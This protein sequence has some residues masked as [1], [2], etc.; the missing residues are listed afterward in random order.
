MNR[1]LRTVLGIGLPMLTILA[2][3]VLLTF[4]LLRLSAIE[5]SMRLEAPHNMLWVISQA[6]VA[7]LRLSKTAAE[8][9]LDLDNAEELQRRHNVFLSRLHLLEQG[10]QWREMAALGLADELD[11]LRQQ[12]PALQAAIAA[13]QPHD[14]QR[15]AAIDTLLDPFNRLL[16]RAANKAMVAE[17]EYVGGRM[18]EARG[19]LWQIIISLVGILLAGVA[20]STHFLLAKRN[21]HQRARLLQQEKAFSEL[22]I[23]SSNDSIVAVDRHG[24]CTVWNRAAEHLFQ[25]PAA[26]VIGRRLDHVSGFFDVRAIQQ[27]IR[28]ALQGNTAILLEQPFFPAAD[29]APHYLGMRYFPLRNDGRIIGAILLI[30]DVTE[31]RAAQQEIAMHRDHLQELVQAR[32]QELD[33]ALER[34][35]AAA[36]LY[37]NFG[38]MISHQFRTPLAI[39]DSALQRL[40]RRSEKMSAAEI[41]A[42]SAK[43]RDAIKRLTLLIESTL[44]AARLDAGQIK[45]RSQ[46]CDLGQLAASVCGQQRRAA[47]GATINLALPA[48]EAPS[49]YCDPAHAEHI[50][51]NLVSNAVKY[52]SADAPI[53]VS[54]RCDDDHTEC[55]VTNQATLADDGE[56]DALFERYYRG[57]NARGHTGIGIG[58]YMARALARLQDGEIEL[59]T[60]HAANTVTFTLRLPRRAAQADSAPPS[61]LEPA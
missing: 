54:I 30:F 33:A 17:W 34:E 14:R 37:R 47:H 10:P 48:T 7:G 27:A 5:N 12:L 42:R 8:R 39:V 2:F 58:L 44:D 6:Q 57:D 61:L 53:T 52:S 35:R 24:L 22:V 51:N 59:H 9:A 50:L 20:L 23:S 4:S 32:T 31:W 45:S 29:A 21:A 36:E 1:S 38:A 60:D 46:I 43:S 18:D 26:A 11:E 49:A 40:A 25:Q 16:G 19:Q 28:Q 55:A 56:P 13:L 15:A 41:R 3:F